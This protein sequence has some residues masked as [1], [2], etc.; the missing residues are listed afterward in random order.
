[1][2]YSCPL[3]GATSNR[4]GNPFDSRQKVVSHIDAKRDEDHAGE[5]GDTYRSQIGEAEPSTATATD[6]GPAASAPSDG[7]QPARETVDMTPEEFDEAVRE[8]REAGYQA[9][10]EDGKADAAD[11]FDP[12]GAYQEGYEDGYEEAQQEATDEAPDDEEVQWLSCGCQGVH[13]SDLPVGE[14]VVVT[15][16]VCGHKD[17]MTRRE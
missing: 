17:K 1:M 7:G 11:E 8:A 6:G 2:P 13:A 12:E 16:D 14:Q 9:G 10:Y 5:R 15:C 4:K 3:C